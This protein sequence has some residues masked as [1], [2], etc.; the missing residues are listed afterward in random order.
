MDTS[1][2]EKNGKIFMLAYDQGLVHGPSDFNEFSV[3][4]Q[5]I[6]QLGIDGGATCLTMQYGI[7]KRFYTTEIRKQIPLILKING[8][9]NLCKANTTMSLTGSVEDAINL[10]AVGIGMTINPG[11]INEADAFN[12]LVILRREAEKA[13]LL[14]AVWSYARG[15]EIKDQ[16]DPKVV[17]YAVRAAAE[18]GA[19]IIKV[20][21]T[22]SSET[23]KWAVENSCGAKVLASGTDNF[24]T[25]YIPAV[26]KMLESG[27]D[28]VAVGRNVWQAANPLATAKAIAETLFS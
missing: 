9:T 3:E 15:P 17:A 11:Q 22:G 27:A 20:K 8:A 23:F 5:N 10:G 28:G 13:G 4:P 14:L 26:K 7:A 24:P 25:D 6:M 1:V 21:Y 18:L 19:D 16:F 2:I 12:Q